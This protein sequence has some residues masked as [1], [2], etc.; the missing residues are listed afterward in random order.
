MHDRSFRV[1][2]YEAGDEEAVAALYKAVYGRSLDLAWYH[3]KLHTL[4]AESGVPNVWV[5]ESDDGLIGHYGGTPH[6]FLLSGEQVPARHTSDA[7]THPAYR[8]QGVYSVVGRTAHA[9]WAEAGEPFLFGL[10]ND[11]W[12]TR[13]AYLGYQKMF[14]A[15]WQQRFLRPELALAA[16]FGI[17]EKFFFPLEMVSKIAQHVWNRSLRRV[18]GNVVVKEVDYPGDEFEEL[19]L[20]LKDCYEAI[21]V[22]NL[23]WVRYRFGDA[24]GGVYTLLLA[25]QG[26]RPSGYLAYRVTTAGRGKV[27]W[28]VDLFSAPDDS[29]TREALLLAALSR[30]FEAGVS[31]VR[32]LV[33]PGIPLFETL[34]KAGF[35]P[36]KGGFGCHIVPLSWPEPLPVFS[37]P[38]KWFT[39]AGDYDII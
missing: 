29:S 2:P 19:W 5:A 24:P 37:D 16:R 23:A 9:A 34:Q 33:P 15:V 31:V 28:L 3:W 22:R 7:M 25:R 36:M 12:G 17:P 10:P 21:L 35:F 30:L 1:R 20:Q 14:P 27:G 38:Q 4:N 11:K 39:L 13:V 8:R 26:Q 18:L 6:Q 32:F